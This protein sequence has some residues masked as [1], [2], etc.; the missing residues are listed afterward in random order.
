MQKAPLEE[1]LGAGGDFPPRAAWLYLD[2]YFRSVEEACGIP[3]IAASYRELLIKCTRR[4]VGMDMK[5]NDTFAAQAAAMALT[6]KYPDKIGDELLYLILVRPFR[7]SSL[8]EGG[9]K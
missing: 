6:K 7:D 2:A 3:E 9:E 8:W 1:R 5:L 4:R